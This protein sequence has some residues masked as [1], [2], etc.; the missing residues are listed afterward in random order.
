MGPIFYLAVSYDFT[1]CNDCQMADKG[2][3][4]NRHHS[5]TCCGLV[6]LRLSE[7]TN[8]LETASR[9]EASWGRPLEALEKHLR[10]PAP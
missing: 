8:A 2:A 3:I 10:L 9:R 6:F 4:P 7:Q 1:S 5:L